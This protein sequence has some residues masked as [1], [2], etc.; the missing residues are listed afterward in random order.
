[1]AEPSADQG[2]P[3]AKRRRRHPQDAEQE[4]LEAA[5]ELLRKRPFHELTIDA[6][7]RRTTLSRKSFYVYF[8]DRYE[9]LRKLVGPLRQEL[10]KANGAF[11]H[12]TGDLVVD[13]RATM[14]GVARVYRD[15]GRL[16]RALSEA[17]AY[18]AQVA[19]LWLQFKEPVIAGFAEKLAAEAR[20]GRAADLDF[21]PVARAL[22]GMNLN[23]LFDQVI[24]DPEV[25]LE[26][27]VET[28]VTIWARVILPCPGSGLA[29]T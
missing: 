6:L 18:D 26:G 21:E 29:P 7:M 15:H 4:I 10:D 24:D 27:L 25:D 23:S 22:L 9:L 20:A 11:L 3:V 28:L 12:G 17:S 5:D 14:L 2:H 1:M 16:I 19:E 8:S 13:G